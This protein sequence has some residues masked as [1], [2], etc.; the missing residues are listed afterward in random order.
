MLKFEKNPAAMFINI[1]LGAMMNLIPRDEFVIVFDRF[2]IL[3]NGIREQDAAFNG[4]GTD[5]LE[6]TQR[7]LPEF[8]ELI[9]T[10]VV[11]VQPVELESVAGPV[12]MIVVE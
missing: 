9:E 2:T 3:E 11:G 4:Q 10:V 12:L 5:W 6:G 7:G 1:K 8:R